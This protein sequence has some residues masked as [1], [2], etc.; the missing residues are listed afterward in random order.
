MNQKE[1][2]G[3]KIR[4]YREDKLGISADKL[5]EMLEPK[6]SGKTVLSWE[7]GRTEPDGNML[8]QLC[9]IFGVDISDFY[10][11]P[12]EYQY[13]VVTIDPANGSSW[14]EI[15]FYGSIAAGT[16]IEM[17]NAEDTY[18]VP[19]KIVNEHP[20]HRLGVMQ[21]DGNSFNAGGIYDKFYVVVDFDDKEPTNSHDPF[22][23][24]I[25]NSTATVKAIE[26]LENGIRLLPNSYDTTIK[27]MTFTYDECNDRDVSVLG[28]VIWTFA[29]FNYRF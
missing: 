18:L 20:G 15:P 25:D 11:K 10:Y 26:K 4:H 22:A 27:P 16:P 9:V 13:A 2:I 28:K 3:K 17:I 7:R 12:S 6:K 24:S 23:V 19:S 14:M 1:Y 21:I 8:I 5:G 29:P